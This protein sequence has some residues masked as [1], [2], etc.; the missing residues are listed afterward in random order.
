M[1]QNSYLYLSIGGTREEQLSTHV[2]AQER[3]PVLNMIS[4]ITLHGQD[5][6]TIVNCRIDSMSPSL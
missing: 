5:N 3:R 1:L 2:V 6:R 4:I